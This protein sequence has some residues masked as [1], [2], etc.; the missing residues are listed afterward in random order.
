MAHAFP[1]TAQL[2]RK[3]GFHVQT[4]DMTELMKAESGVTCSSL[5]ID[6]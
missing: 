5:I 3:N 1:E 6:G 2:L 4:L